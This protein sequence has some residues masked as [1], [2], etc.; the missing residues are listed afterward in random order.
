MVPG[1]AVVFIVCWVVVVG[2]FGFFKCEFL[3]IVL[4]WHSLICV[5][6][7]GL[8]FLGVLRVLLWFVFV[9]WGVDLVS[10]VVLWM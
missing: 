10:F 3:L 1:Y 8:R 5:A 2:G 7:F 4:V 6:L 9:E